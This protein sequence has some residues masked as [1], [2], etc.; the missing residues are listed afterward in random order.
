[1]QAKGKEREWLRHQTHGDL[2]EMKLIEGITGEKAIYRRRG[3]KD[4]EVSAALT[5]IICSPSPDTV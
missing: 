3:E 5:E 2:D 4:P 1:M